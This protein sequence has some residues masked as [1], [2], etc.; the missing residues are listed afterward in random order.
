MMIAPKANGSNRVLMDDKF[1]QIGQ[2]IFELNLPTVQL[3]ISQGKLGDVRGSS[4]EG[5]KDIFGSDG[6]DLSIDELAVIHE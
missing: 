3:D 2:V 1:R 6:E 5:S 4:L